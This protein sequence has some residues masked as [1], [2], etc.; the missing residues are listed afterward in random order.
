MSETT[1]MDPQAEQRKRDEWAQQHPG[2]PYP[3]E[4]GV[5]SGVRGPD[6]IVLTELRDQIAKNPNAGKSVQALIEGM[7]DKMVEAVDRGASPDEV[8]ANVAAVVEAFKAAAP[9]MGHAILAN[10]PAEGK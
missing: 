1:T 4:P 3:A 9:A 7:A 2:E 10:T 5:H 8:K 6:P